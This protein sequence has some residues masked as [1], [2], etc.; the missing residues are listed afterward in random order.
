MNRKIFQEIKA[1]QLIVEG[2][3]EEKGE[4]EEGEGEEEGEKEGEGEIEG[5]DEEAE[6]PSI[7]QQYQHSFTFQLLG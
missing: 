2:G 6:K 3:G 4:G 7:L 5:E 1:L